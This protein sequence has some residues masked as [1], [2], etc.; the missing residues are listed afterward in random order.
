MCADYPL[1]P[2]VY[3]TSAY[4][5]CYADTP[6]GAWPLEEREKRKYIVNLQAMKKDPKTGK[7]GPG[8]DWIWLGI[9]E[10]G[11]VLGMAHEHVR[12]DR[13]KF[14][15]ID[16]SRTKKAELKYWAPQY[17]ID[18]HTSTSLP[19][20]YSSIMHYSNKRMKPINCAPNCPKKLGNRIGL[21]KLDQKQLIELYRCKAH[22]INT[23]HEI[24][25]ESGTQLTRLYECADLSTHCRK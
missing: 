7:F 8:C 13:D 21:S 23:W 18:P 25:K 6:H 19:Y 5:G 10:L 14:I 2:A 22:Q 15:K 17:K 11:H 3:F 12:R 24:L 16:M 4:E 1:L 9:H 20:D